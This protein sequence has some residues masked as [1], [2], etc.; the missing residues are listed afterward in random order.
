MAAWTTPATSTE[1]APGIEAF[2]FAVKGRKL[3]VSVKTSGEVSL[4]DAA[5]RPSAS[6][7]KKKRKKPLLRSS[8][9]SGGSPTITVP[10]ALTKTAKAKL[11]KKGKV[12]AKARITFTPEGFG[13]A[14]SQTAKLTFRGKRKKK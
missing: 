14:K 11:K 13:P 1:A 5:A 7:A 6:A 8:S 2:S 9:A 3:I 4:R 12:T 10:L